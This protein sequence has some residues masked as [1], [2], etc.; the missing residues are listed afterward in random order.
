MSSAISILE[1][2]AESRPSN[3]FEWSDLLHAM[4]EVVASRPSWQAEAVLL[5]ILRME[6]PILLKSTSPT[7]HAMPPHEML[8]SLAIQFLGK[9]TGLAYVQE[10]ER[11]GST[12]DSSILTS[13]VEMVITSARKNAKL[14]TTFESI[15][16]PQ[17]SA[18]PQRSIF[19]PDTQT[20]EIVPSLHS[21]PKSVQ[22][23][24]VGFGGTTY[25]P[26]RRVNDTRSQLS[27][28][29]AA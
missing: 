5:R 20:F 12:A 17:A 27:E 10:M 24:I 6:G 3:E 9:W 8:K 14:P 18:A 19:S 13:I 28:A 29:H 15:E 26:T 22:Q 21:Q 4:H 11:V 25:L 2:V 1:Q 7:P 23:P 16:E